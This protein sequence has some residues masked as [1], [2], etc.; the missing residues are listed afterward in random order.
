MGDSAWHSDREDATEAGM[1][2]LFAAAL[3]LLVAGC[4]APVTEADRDAFM[5]NIGGRP[6]QC[7]DAL[8]ASGMPADQA[9]SKCVCFR[10]VIRREASEDL[11]RATNAG[12]SGRGPQDSAMER[13]TADIQRASNLAFA[14]CGIDMPR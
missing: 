2:V 14:N 3:G 7:E 13:L 6:N 8:G 11:V 9:A 1:R 10:R 5:V 4:A 12:Q